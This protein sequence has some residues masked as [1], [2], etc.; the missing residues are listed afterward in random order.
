[1]ASPCS[2]PLGVRRVRVVALLLTVALGIAS[3]KVTTGWSPIDKSLGDV[4]YAVAVFFALGVVMPRQAWR[5]L[6]P[7]TALTCAA[8]EAFQATG[9]PAR[10][11]DWLVVRWL[12]GTTFAVHDLL[13]YAIGV[14]LAAVV[15]RAL[16]RHRAPVSSDESK[17]R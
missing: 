10:H 4:L 2:D 7:V 9:L 14:G 1:M 15:D 11:A 12:I 5:A 13:C 17:E 6:A 16:E 3:R 8:I